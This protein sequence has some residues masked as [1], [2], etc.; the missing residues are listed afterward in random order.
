V[1]GAS[2]AFLDDHRNLRHFQIN[3]FD[4]DFFDALSLKF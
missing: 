4:F 3:F 2:R 1:K